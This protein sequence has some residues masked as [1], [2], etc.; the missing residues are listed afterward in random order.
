MYSTKT[1][2][3]AIAPLLLAVSA[4]VDFDLDDV[5]NSCK[6]ICRPV[7]QL[8]SQCDVDLRSDNDRDEN[9]LQAQCVCTNTSFDV[10]K[11]AGL[12]ADCM[13]QSANS[14]NRD[15][16]RAD[17]DDLRGKYCL[18]SASYLQLC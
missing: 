9:L 8:S 5:P 18:F 17:R 16:D 6:A 1:L 4:N 15:D 11:I 2:A 14:Q 10:G 3:L 7:A 12:C 13:H